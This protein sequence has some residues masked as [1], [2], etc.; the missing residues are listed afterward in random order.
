MHRPCRPL[1]VNFTMPRGPVQIKG[2]AATVLVGD[3]TTGAQQPA[4]FHRDK[5]S[6]IRPKFLSPLF[7]LYFPIGTFETGKG[8]SV[9]GR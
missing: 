8:G 1:R 5:T 7:L 6:R 9:V 4:A 2:S 3:F